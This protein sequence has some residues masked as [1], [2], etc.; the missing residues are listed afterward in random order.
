MEYEDGRIRCD[1][2]GLVIRWYGLF[3]AKKVPYDRIRSATAGDMGAVGGRFRSWG[4]SDLRHWYNLDATRPHKKIAIVLELGGWVRPVTTPDEPD[5]VI[6]ILG[7]RGV[8][9]AAG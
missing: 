1:E 8:G 6:G 3:G 7:W 2:R 4:T 5:K 9:V